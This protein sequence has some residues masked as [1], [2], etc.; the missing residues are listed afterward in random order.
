MCRTEPLGDV[1][2][3]HHALDLVPG[4]G[5]GRRL[6]RQTPSVR[7]R[8]SRGRLRHGQPREALRQS[9][10]LPLAHR[11][12]EHT[13]RERDDI[14]GSERLERRHQAER[15]VRDCTESKSP[16]GKLPNAISSFSPTGERPNFLARLRQIFQ[17]LHV[18]PLQR[19][20]NS[21]FRLLTQTLAG[22]SARI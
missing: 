16:Y 7:L 8:R 18:K 4:V 6:R 13:W 14:P 22:A 11:L 5:L 19:F 3:V 21:P 12:W 10:A 15:S 1:E 20:P 17:F 2:P 9:L